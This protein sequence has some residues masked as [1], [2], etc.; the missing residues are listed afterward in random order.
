MDFCRTLL[1]AA[2][3]GGHS[4]FLVF[5]FMICLYTFAVCDALLFIAFTIVMTIHSFIFI[6]EFYM[7][8][9]YEDD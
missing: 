6:A 1:A 5:L 4:R 3:S 2:F 8:E 7:R 9:R